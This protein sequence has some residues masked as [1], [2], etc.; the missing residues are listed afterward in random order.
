[1]VK[2][3]IAYK[4]QAF[5][6]KFHLFGAISHLIKQIALIMYINYIYL[7]NRGPMKNEDGSL[8]PDYYVSYKENL[9]PNDLWQYYLGT[10]FVML[11]IP[12]YN[13]SQ[14]AFKVGLLKFVTVGVNWLDILHVTI[15]FYSCYLQF[16][17]GPS[18][19]QSILI[20]ILSIILCLIK[21]FFYMKI[22]ESFSFIVTM[23]LQVVI[24]L[25][26]F[27]LFFIILIVMFSMIFN[28]IAPPTKPEYAK[29]G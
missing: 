13:D 23:I 8:N 19:T 4:W 26:V 21:T 22:F 9:L 10:I 24:D 28:V 12:L 14:Q 16:F 29:V 5:A 7:H 20:L 2:E 15:G 3:L 27:I 18:G 11:F 1:V 25:K 6:F 17:E